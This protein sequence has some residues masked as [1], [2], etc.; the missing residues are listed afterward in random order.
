MNSEHP[1][2]PFK[3]QRQTTVSTRINS[4]KEFMSYFTTRRPDS[5]KCVIRLKVSW[6]GL[7]RLILACSLQEP[8]PL[9]S[10]AA[11]YSP[12]LLCCNVLT[13][14]C[15]TW[16]QGCS[17]RIWKFLVP[18]TAFSASFM[19]LLLFL[20]SSNV[21]LFSVV[22]DMGDEDISSSQSTRGSTETAH[23]DVS[24]TVQ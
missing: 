18:Q 11:L 8:T 21:I 4:V 20:V 16:F 19:L 24:N 14:W 23:P 1:L 3:T 5:S 22:V 10:R 15:W 13:T 6:Q 12:V 7:N 9:P 17:S 2:Q